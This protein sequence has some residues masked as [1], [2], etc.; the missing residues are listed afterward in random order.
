LKTIGIYP[1]R[2]KDVLYSGTAEVIA[3]L[4]G[5]ADILIDASLQDEL[6]EILGI[7]RLNSVRFV[8]EEKLFTSS[9]VIIV[10]GGDGTILKAARRCAPCGVPLVGINLGRVGYMAE[11]ELGELQLL[12]KIFTND[13]TI[14]KR[15]M[16]QANIGEGTSFAL[17]DAVLAA[18]SLFRMAD[19]ELYCDGK[20]ANS[21]RAGGLIASTPTGS[22]AYSLSAG[23]AVVDPCMD[24][25]I[26]TPICSHSLSAASVVFSAES[27]LEMKNICR[28]G[29]T[30]YLG[31]DGSETYTLGYLESVR[32]VRSHLRVNF[33]R[34]KDGGFYEVL[35]KKMAETI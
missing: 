22:T 12:Q 10:L 20:L 8:C 7:N 29:E 15:M 35:R 24:A 13:Y 4:G 28:H 3:A 18:E 31:I 33:L 30:L 11:L 34:L 9:E 14:E 19:I 25:I 23:G 2:E 1:N 32:I 6:I 16:L 26:I 5:K 17:N 27:V 21:Y